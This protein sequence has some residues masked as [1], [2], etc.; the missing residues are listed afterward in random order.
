MFSK[1]RKHL[2]IMC[3]LLILLIAILG[4]VLM[5]VYSIDDYCQEY[6]ISKIEAE[7]KVVDNDISCIISNAENMLSILE[8]SYASNSDVLK[9]LNNIK[10]TEFIK[11][12]DSIVSDV[13][14]ID[15]NLLYSMKE[16]KNINAND[17]KESEWYKTAVDKKDIYISNCFDDFNSG[18]KC[19]AICKKINSNNAVA[20][21]CIK[22][23]NL[24]NKLKLEEIE[25]AYIIN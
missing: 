21:V 10:S 12:A 24:I 22:I 4:I 3:L 2:N 16:N 18:E 8:M 5:G 20:A 23:S 14:V 19:I 1:I 13:Y 17:A 25:E 15:N 11:K 6:I 7:D 9:I